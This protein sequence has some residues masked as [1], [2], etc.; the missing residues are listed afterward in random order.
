[1]EFAPAREFGTPLRKLESRPLEKKCS[2]NNSFFHG[3][4]SYSV[5]SWSSIASLFSRHLANG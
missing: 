5:S 4:R 3:D 2:R 1:L